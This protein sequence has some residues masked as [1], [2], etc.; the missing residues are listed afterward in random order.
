MKASVCWFGGGGGVGTE[1]TLASV[2]WFGTGGG[3]G[4]AATS[5]ECG[6]IGVVGVDGVVGVVDGL[7]IAVGK[8]FGVDCSALTIDSNVKECETYFYFKI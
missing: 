6:A 1:S 7:T 5:V 2:C 3:F 8:P 4:I